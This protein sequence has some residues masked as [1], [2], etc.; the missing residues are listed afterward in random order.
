MKI[1]EYK[2]IVFHPY[3]NACKHTGTVKKRNWNWIENQEKDQKRDIFLSELI[4][5][6]L[7]LC[8]GQYSLCSS[9]TNTHFRLIFILFQNY[10]I[11]FTTLH[12]FIFPVFP[13]ILS[14]TPFILVF[15]I[16]SFHTRTFVL[17]TDLPEEIIKFT[18]I[19]YLLRVIPIK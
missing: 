11:I 5:L 3:L 18:T 1:L 16:C 6:L 13:K 10:I 17:H 14:S 4:S 15:S 2:K 12:T 8:S 19:N 7:S 9:L